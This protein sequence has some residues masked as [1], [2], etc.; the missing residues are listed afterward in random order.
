MT[1]RREQFGE[2]PWLEE[3]DRIE[4][5]HE[6]LTCLILR[7]PQLGHLCGYVAIPAEHPWHG[8]EYDALGDVTV[9]GGL[10]YSQ[11]M[12]DH[13]CDALDAATWWLG[14]DCA[15]AYD[16]APYMAKL[17]KRMERLLPDD[18]SLYKGVPYVTEQVGDLAAQVVRAATAAAR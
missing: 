18:I 10:T 6:G 12:P 9:H 5:Q 16:F 17:T 7:H 13:G 8:A 1:D 11:E 2:G 15:H 4:W 3:P 14:F